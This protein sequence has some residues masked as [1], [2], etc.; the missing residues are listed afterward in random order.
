MKNSLVLLAV[1]LSVAAFAGMMRIKT[2]VQTMDRERLRL[3]R[4]RA[5][6]RETK[7]V[8]EAEW[9]LLA[10]PDRL[11]KLMNGKAYVAANSINIVPLMPK[12]SLTAVVATPTALI[13]VVTPTVVD[14]TPVEGGAIAA[15][16]ALM[17][18]DPSSSATAAEPAGEALVP[19]TPE[20]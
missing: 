12:V 15:V 2:D 10:S 3:V 4:E 1:V 6:L 19:T 9:A 5:E 20:E 17:A 14:A 8:L 11:A 18:T 7:R 13:P 16:E